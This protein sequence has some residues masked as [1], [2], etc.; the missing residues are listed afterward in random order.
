MTHTPWYLPKHYAI[1]VYFLAVPSTVPGITSA[2]PGTYCVMNKCWVNYH[3]SYIFICKNMHAS[4]ATNIGIP[5]FSSS[6][7]IYHY[8]LLYEKQTFERKLP[9]SLIV[10]DTLYRVSRKILIALRKE[11]VIGSFY[12]SDNYHVC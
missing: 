9:S 3:T 11:Y 5:A 6:H 12:F 1:H 7:S 8:S 4:P 10:S 2:M